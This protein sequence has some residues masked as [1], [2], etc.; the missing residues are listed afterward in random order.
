MKNDQILPFHRAA[1][2]SQKL[3]C[4]SSPF[5]PDK[6]HNEAVRIVRGESSCQLGP[7]EP[8]YCVFAEAAAEQNAALGSVSRA[9]QEQVDARLH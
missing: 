4:I 3:P 6:Q 8:T 5:E 9:S 7:R 1:S 2:C